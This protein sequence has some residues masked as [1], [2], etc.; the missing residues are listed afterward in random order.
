M[1]GD[2]MADYR[3]MYSH[4]FNAV[5]DALEELHMGEIVEAEYRLKMAQ[6][7]CEDIFHD[8]EPDIHIGQP[9]KTIEIQNKD[10]KRK[11]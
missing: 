3:Q 10:T 7:K 2:F 5:T 11:G 9:P 6:M 4:L 1:M 8:T